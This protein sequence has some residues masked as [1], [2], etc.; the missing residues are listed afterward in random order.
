MIAPYPRLDTAEYVSAGHPDRL[1]DTI[2]ERLVEFGQAQGP[3]D[4]L[5]RSLVGVEVAVYVGAGVA[6]TVTEISFEGML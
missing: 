3:P 5:S 4:R 2:A 1:A 6:A